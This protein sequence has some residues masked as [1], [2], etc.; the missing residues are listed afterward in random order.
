MTPL[1]VALSQLHVRETAPNRG[2]E[3]DE[4]LASC[5]IDPTAGS[6]PWCVAFVRWCCSRVGVWLPRT[7]SVKRLWEMGEDLRVD[8]PQ[9]GDV[10]IHLRPDGLGHC[11]FFMR[12]VSASNS[13]DKAETVDG[14]TNAEGSREGDRVAIKTRPWGYWN[15]GFLRPRLPV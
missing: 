3:V 5:G 7:V 6:F 11:G 9:P 13:E 8:N 2:P 4:Y 12:W 15:M 14:N 1:D 10:A